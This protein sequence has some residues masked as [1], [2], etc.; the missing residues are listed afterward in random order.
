MDHPQ[1]QGECHGPLL[2]KS[3][4]SLRSA[5]SGCLLK[6]V[7]FQ[8]G[9][10]VQFEPESVSSFSRNH[11]PVC[12]GIGVQFGPE[13]LSS[14]GRNTHL[15]SAASGSVDIR[16]KKEPFRRRARSVGFTIW[17]PVES[18][19]QSALEA[20]G[21]IREVRPRKLGRPSPPCHGPVPH[22]SREEW[23]HEVE[24]ALSV[25]PL[26]TKD[27]EGVTGLMKSRPLASPSMRDARTLEESSED[28]V[29]RLRLIEAAPRRWEERCLGLSR[30]QLCGVGLESL[31][32]L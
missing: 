14:L 3:R 25:P 2:G 16:Q 13:S 30:P 31:T 6:T 23:E 28:P 7:Q 20:L 27:G 32:Q 24:V 29:D 10:S 4:V 11:C 8:T 26:K 22:I 17:S 15:H 9:I 19:V 1:N 18:R 5:D 12:S 21:K